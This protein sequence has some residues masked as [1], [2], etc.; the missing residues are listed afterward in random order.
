MSKAILSIDPGSAGYLCLRKEDGTFDF[1]AIEDCDLYTL[2]EIILQIKEEHKDI[3]CVVEDVHAVFGSSAKSTFSF[4]MNVGYIRG[5]LAAAKIPYVTVAPKVWQKCVWVNED[6][7][8]TYKTIKVQNK[9]VSKKMI[10]TKQTS[11]KC[12]KRLF[13]DIDFR[14]NER[15]K[16]IH[17]GKCDSIL[18]NE[19][20]RR[21][22]L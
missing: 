14:K 13:P 5:V 10:N 20:A 15:C 7:V 3:V 8:A 11:I 16:K 12:A 21:Y 9:E 17:D 1:V 2:S 22:N 18:I 19:Y 4:G 6:I